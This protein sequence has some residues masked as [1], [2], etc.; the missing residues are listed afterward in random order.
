MYVDV[1]RVMIMKHWIF[2]EFDAALIVTLY[3]SRLKLCLEQAHEKFLQPN[4]F[5]PYQT[6]S[7][8]LGLSWTQCAWSFLLV[9]QI[10]SCWTNI[11][12][13]SWCALLVCGALYP[14]CIGKA[15][16]LYCPFEIS[17][18]RLR[19]NLN[20]FGKLDQKL[21]QRVDYKTYIWSCV[22]RIHYRPNHLPVKC[23][24]YLLLS[25]CIHLPLVCD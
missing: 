15:L 12:W 22:H 18:H 3:H 16:K 17:Q 24:I 7:H 13:A 21:A 20:C 2:R 10:N 25:R 4:S 19:S 5:S 14:I 23:R 6:G 11:G 8:V 9:E 1:L